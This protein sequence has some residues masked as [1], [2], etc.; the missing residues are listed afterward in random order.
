MRKT[1]AHY[2]P[3][4]P[5]EFEELWKNGA[6]VV[7]TNVLLDLYRYSEASRNEFAAV[8]RLLSERLWIPHQ[9]A[10]EFH[11]NRLQVID[12][13]LS[14]F[15][16]LV[17][18]L[19][20]A[21]GSLEAEM[22]AYSKNESM[23]IPALVTRHKEMSAELIGM[24][25]AAKSAHPR[26][27]SNIDEDATATMVTELFEDRVGEPFDETVMKQVYEE[28]ARRYP[29]KVPPGYKDSDKPEPDRY[30]DLVLWKQ[31]LK[32]A[33]D[34]KQDLI[35]ITGDLKEDWWRRERGKTIG[36]RPELVREFRKDAGGQVHFYDP[37]QFLQRAHDYL[38]AKISQSTY[39]ELDNL[40]VQSEAN[41]QHD[42][43]DAQLE[44]ERVRAQIRQATVRLSL[45]DSP[46][47]GAV[48]SA[49]RI[50]SIEEQLRI[51]E[52]S[53][54]R[55]EEAYRASDDA[56]KQAELTEALVSIQEKIDELFNAY[57]DEQETQSSISNKPLERKRLLSELAELNRV[58]ETW[59]SR[60]SANKIEDI[61]SRRSSPD[62]H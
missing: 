40:S 16:A 52:K 46:R 4:T 12:E 61:L 25:T 43:V 18:K 33:S 27:P 58:H 31:M 2:Y 38:D 26:V 22:N 20:S 51:M 57:I 59:L 41:R 45:L 60:L 35:F 10:L 53:K 7:D 28:G 50:A 17:K 5:A 55:Y 62:R 47:M 29:A 56:S 19:E 30:G 9:V 32:F 15:D 37:K 21:R 48:A 36:A 3:P 23:D 8:L 54:K 14:A 44:A 34:T 1:L 42:I 24:V 39:D 49:T 6:I 13:Q 11:K